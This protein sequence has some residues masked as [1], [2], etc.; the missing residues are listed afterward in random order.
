MAAQMACIELEKQLTFIAFKACGDI[1][2]PIAESITGH[3]RNASEFANYG[4][5]GYTLAQ[6]KAVIERILI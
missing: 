4:S 3:G 6:K 1:P 2:V 5:V